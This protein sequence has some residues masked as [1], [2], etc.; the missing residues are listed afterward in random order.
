[1]SPDLSPV[2]E[3][4]PAHGRPCGHARSGACD[5]GRLV[6][7]FPLV[8]GCGLPS[9]SARPVQ[10][11][12][13]RRRAWARLPVLSRLGRD[14]YRR[15]RSADADL[16]ELPSD[17]DEGQRA[18]RTDS[19]QRSRAAAR[20]AGFASTSFPHYAYFAHNVHVAAGIGCV[21]CHGRIDEMETV[22]QMTPLSMSWCLDCHR[23]PAPYRRPV[24][25]VTNMRWTPPRD[26]ATLA[27]QLDKV[28][29]VNPP[30]DCSGCHR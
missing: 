4:A 21:S 1:M 23:N 22:T 26:V 8:H 3:Q 11:P 14:F 6:L 15:Q 12:A 25:E 27:A 9:R 16:H 5:R 30:T 18:A 7:L 24:S 13:S 10:P 19:G 29:P 17:R 20:C 2:V 28:R